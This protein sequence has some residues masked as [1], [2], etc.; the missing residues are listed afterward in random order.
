L[1]GKTDTEIAVFKAT[2]SLLD[3][4]PFAELSV[5]QIISVAGIS[6]GSF[7]KYFS[8]KLGVVAGLLVTVMDEVFELAN[9]F[10]IRPQMTM[11]E[12][13]R[14]SIENAMTVWTGHRVLL[15]VVMENWASSVEL[16]AQWMGAMSRYAAAIAAEI[17]QLREA[18][19]LPAG[20]PSERLATALVWSTER[21]L[22]VAGRGA[23]SATSID[24]NSPDELDQI[25][26]LVAIWAGTLNFTP[27]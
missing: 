14:A 5:A 26:I 11:T 25:E 1:S 10:L 8:S 22:Y 27:T 24:D 9:P 23:E 4:H 3:Q 21:C 6:R 19:R 20:L 18:G 7:Y 2:E 16:E 17:D 13:L 15:R 12:S